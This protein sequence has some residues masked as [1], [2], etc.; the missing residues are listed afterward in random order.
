[1]HASSSW[2]PSCAPLIGASGQETLQE[3]AVLVLVLDGERMV[4]VWPF[5]QLLEVDR[6]TLVIELE[7]PIF[8]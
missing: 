1:M 4:R 8:R 3:V 6:G 2:A 5:E 7:Y